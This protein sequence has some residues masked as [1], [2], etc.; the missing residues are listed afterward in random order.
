[1]YRAQVGMPI[2]YFYGYKTDGIFQ[3]YDQIAEYKAAGKGVLA[4]A[5]PGDVI[6]TDYHKDGVIDDNA[7]PPVSDVYHFKFLP[8]A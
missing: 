5:Q 3:N 7:V 1:M 2:G 4:G 8:G 6:F